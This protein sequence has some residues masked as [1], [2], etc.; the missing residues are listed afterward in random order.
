MMS[1]RPNLI[2]GTSPRSSAGSD[3]S[4]ETSSASISRV[5]TNPCTPMS[6]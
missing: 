1:P 6:G 3:A 2:P 5:I 4:V